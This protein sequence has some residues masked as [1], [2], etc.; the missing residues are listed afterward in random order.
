MLR[1]L[2][3]DRGG[4]YVRDICAHTVSALRGN[5]ARALERAM[6]ILT[7]NRAALDDAGQRLRVEETR[8]A[9][10]VTGRG[11]ANGT[12][13]YGAVGRA[14]SGAATPA[15]LSRRGWLLRLTRAGLRGLLAG[16]RGR[17]TGNRTLAG[18]IG[19]GRIVLFLH[20]RL[21]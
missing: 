1:L 14:G 6:Q 7:T 2:A 18:E 3:T 13:R 15:I 19:D 20:A 12:V 17:R 10:A 16:S 8:G 4:G 11:H 9:G 21:R 5:V